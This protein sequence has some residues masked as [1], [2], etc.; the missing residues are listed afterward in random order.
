LASTDQAALAGLRAGQKL[1]AKVALRDGRALSLAVTILPPRPTVTLLAESARP[2]PG[3]APAIPIALA[4]GHDLARGAVLTFSIQAPAAMAARETVE[5]ETSDGAYLTTLSPGA[6]LIR[7]DS[8]VAVATLDT[9]AAFGASAFGPLRFRLTDPRGT[10]DWQDL[11]GLVRLPTLNA[12]TCPPPTEGLCRLTGAN[13]FLLQAVASRPSFEDAVA[14]PEGFPGDQLSVPRPRDG[15]LYLRLHDDPTIVAV[16]EVS[17]R[18][19][20][21]GGATPK[22]KLPAS[23]ISPSPPTPVSPPAAPGAPMP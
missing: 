23:A 6:G 1:T 22:A 9:A 2:P 4:G 16:A 11:A 12:V 3:P 13:L 5:I 19:R 21:A 7:E 8:R 20:K 15:R 17:T 18:R 10:S 14:V